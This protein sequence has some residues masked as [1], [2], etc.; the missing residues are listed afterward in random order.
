MVANKTAGDNFLKL[1][2]H[3]KNASEKDSDNSGE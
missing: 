3:G 1:V 2:A